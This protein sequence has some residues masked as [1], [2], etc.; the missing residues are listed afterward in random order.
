MQIYENY[1]KYI[2][3]YMLIYYKFYL[4]LIVNNINLNFSKG[5]H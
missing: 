4:S 2:T 1:L 3:K 5:N